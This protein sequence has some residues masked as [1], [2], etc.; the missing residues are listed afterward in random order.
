MPRITLASRIPPR[1]EI[2]ANCC[3]IASCVVPVRAPIFGQ[4]LHF[5]YLTSS[6]PAGYTSDHFRDVK[7]LQLQ[8]SFRD[9]LS[10]AFAPV[11]V[12]L[13]FWQPTAES[14]SRRS[15]PVTLVNDEDREIEGTLTLALE[16]MQNQRVA[17]QADRFKIAP[18]GRNTQYYEFTFPDTEGD[19]LLRAIIQYTENGNR[20]VHAKPPAGKDSG[21]REEGKLNLL[22]IVNSSAPK[23]LCATENV[24]RV[25]DFDGA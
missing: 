17:T 12:N 23:S 24:P 10:N 22:R 19:F 20:S 6:D 5:V 18:L 11:G 15:L 4:V 14:G 2:K 25:Y 3:E 1:R 21:A 9:Y 7:N 13:S 8:P 16:N